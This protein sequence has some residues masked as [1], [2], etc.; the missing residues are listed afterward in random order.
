MK[1]L[2]L[3]LTLVSSPLMANTPQNLTLYFIPSPLGMDWSSP[4]NIAIS[5]L[6]NKL[7]FK[8]HFMGHVFVEL[9]CGDKKVVTGMVGKNFDYLNQLLVENRGLGVLYHSFDG[10]LE[11]RSDVELEIEEL[12]K[13]SGRMNFVRFGL[14]E[15]QCE[16]GLT[17]LKEYRDK[18]VGRYYGLANRPRHGEGAGCSA[19]GASFAEVTG[20]MDIDLQEAWSQTINIPLEFAGPPLK[21]EGVNLFKLMLNG[22]SWATEKEPHQKL[23]FWSPDRMFDWVKLKVSK[24]QQEKH[25]TVTELGKTQ[26]IFLD[27]SHLPAPSGPIWLQ[28]LDPKNNK[29]TKK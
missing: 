26:G 29:M 3:L 20:V 22:G 24:S 21:P 18:K 12:S 8:P 19:F 14:N 27:K 25:F 28:R 17:Y 13:E 6:K 7:T 23:M 10:H 4:A 11:N 9:R 5:A 15:G 1:K 2:L 16:R